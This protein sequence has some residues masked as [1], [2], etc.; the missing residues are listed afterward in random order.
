MENENKTNSV[1]QL[2]AKAAREKMDF[3]KWLKSSPPKCFRSKSEV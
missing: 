1:S 3:E 2:T